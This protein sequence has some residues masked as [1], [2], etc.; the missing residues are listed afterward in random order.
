MNEDIYVNGQLLAYEDA[1]IAP[2]D[3]GFLHGAG[4]F[5]TLRTH[6][7]KVFRLAQHLDRLTT[8]AQILGL[9]F[10]LSAAQLAEMVTDLLENNDLLHTDARV[11][12]TLTR[13]DLQQITPE[14][15]VPPVTLVLSAAA[16]SPYPPEAYDKGATVIVSRYKQNPDNPLCG[17]KTTS[18]FDRMLALRDAHAARALEALWFT[19]H[20]NHLAEGS[21]SNVFIVDRDGLLATP[22][23]APPGNPELRLCLPGITRQVILELAT[24]RNI[25]PHERLLTI[26]DLLQAREIFLTNAIMG[27]MPVTHIERHS[28]ANE[29]PGE[30]AR[31][32][33]QDYEAFIV[34]STQ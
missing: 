26:D 7:G 27:V 22:P 30:L 32:L 34:S 29:K 5:E 1:R 20:T 8:S 16:F 17:H 21:I 31:Q 14:N 6:H 11:R 33:R 10:S 12:I 19:V 9:T 15:P 18:Y 23:L 28:V 4:L 24:Q 25:L 2:G 3:A 13:G